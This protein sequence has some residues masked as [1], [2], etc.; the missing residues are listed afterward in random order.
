[1]Q[2]DSGGGGENFCIRDSGLHCGLQ[3][4]TIGGVGLA[5]YRDAYD[6][7]GTGTTRFDF[8]FSVKVT[9]TLPDSPDPNPGA[10]RLNFQQAFWRYAFSL[11]PHFGSH[12]FSCAADSYHSGFAAGVPVDIG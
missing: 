5:G 3:R 2:G 9:D 8:H 10:L 6:H 7:R 12:S 11:I 1:M 4:F